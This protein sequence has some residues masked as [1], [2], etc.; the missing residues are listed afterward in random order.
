VDVAAITSAIRR[1]TRLANLGGDAT[2]AHI[3]T[4]INEGGGY[5]SGLHRWPFL[6][7]GPTNITVV[8]GTV[9][10]ALNTAAWAVNTVVR[11]GKS[12]MLKEVSYDNYLRAVGD[13]PTSSSEA[14]HYYLKADTTTPTTLNLGLYPT[15]SANE[16]NAYKYTWFKTWTDLTT[17]SPIW[18]AQFHSILVD[19]GAYR[20]WEREEYFDE[21]R[22][23]YGR[24]T[25]TLKDMI[26]FYNMQSR[27]TELIYGD[28]MSPVWDERLHL[29]IW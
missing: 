2:D 23:A 15:P 29:P 3:L 27:D 21:A 6:L 12:R 5:V 4:I 7:N 17:G 11:A 26:R 19:Y 16:S 9:E 28:G 13:D 10:Y 14:T 18:H 20:L 8:A 24:F 1:Q 22:D 25:R